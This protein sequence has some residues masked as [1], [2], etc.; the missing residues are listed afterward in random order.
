MTAHAEAPAQPDGDERLSYRGPFQRLLTRPEIGAMV[1]AAAIWI[2][3]WLVNDVF[4]TSAGANNFLDV[5]T[6]LGIMA[7]AVALLMVG[8]EFDLSAGA[9]T[10]ASG[11]LLV[12]LVKDTGEFGGAGLPMAVA[13]PI[14]FAFA[15]GVGWVNGTLVERTGL[16]SFIVTLG[17]FFVLRGAKLGF[18]KLFT[19]KVIAEGLDDAPDF[20]FFANFFGSVWI[21]NDHVWDSFL[22]GRNIVFAV[23]ATIGAVALA[24]GMLELSLVRREKF[25][26]SGL[27]VFAIGLA[28]AVGGLLFLASS[29][30]T[31]ANWIGGALVAAG[32]LVGAVGFAR[33]RHE[34]VTDSIDG[35]FSLAGE[36]G[37]RVALGVG[38]MVAGVLAGV[39]LDSTSQTIVGFL[40]T[41]QGLRAILFVGL[42]VAGVIVLLGAVSRARGSRTTQLVVT[43]VTALMTVG[44]AFVVQAEGSGR[45]TRAE[46][47]TVI[48]VM[49]LAIAVIGLVRYRYTVRRFEDAMTDRTGRML[50]ITGLGL[51]ASAVI[52]RLLYSTTAE[53]E[54]SA[55]IIS[56]RI[57]VFYFLVF[58]IFASWLLLKT[59]FGSWTFAVGGNAPASRQVGV[60]TARTKTRL[61]ML[62]SVAA[63]LV[64]T[65]IAFRL[66]SVQANVG[67]GQEFFYII[68]AVVGGCL[69]TGGY[70][71]AAGAAIGAVIMAMSF[72]GIPF[73]GWN[74][75][76]RFL[77]VGVILLLAVMVNNYVRQRAEAAR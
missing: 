71:S 29:D 67:D 1:G 10:G 53:N 13:L 58:A 22:G 3:F 47:F 32:V 38:L 30:S 48:L 59:K 26:R 19:D 64:G 56:Y 28:G 61:F 75:D 69:L 23:L 34:P 5:S 70:G 63:W 55:A 57:A 44:V 14:T 12:L 49:A 40:L 68:A 65:L 42:V 7:L 72:Q 62:V 73:S 39:V 74:S 50:A 18:A 54:A 2:F 17:T 37:R 60:P 21:R 52:I 8:G 31:S 35:G 20:D 45:K 16:P 77:F 41:V 27:L 46:L 66:N 36:P 33:W 4:G 25:D 76:W 6:S 9:M 43:L 51:M 24:A 11:M 15:L